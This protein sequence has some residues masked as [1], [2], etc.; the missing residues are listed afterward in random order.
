MTF[1]SNSVSWTDARVE[2]LTV[3]W[4][5]G[6]SASQIASRLGGVTRNA[7]IGKLH[8]LGVAGRGAPSTPRTMRPPRQA[9]HR[10]VVQ[11]PTRTPG[12]VGRP[13]LVSGGT[14]P[15]PVIEGPPLV[16][17]L[18]LLGAHACRWPIGDPRSSAFG[19]CGRT[20]QRDPYCVDHAC[21][22][23]RAAAPFD[24]KGFLR[25]VAGLR[26]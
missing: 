23:Y 4:R 17:D 6:L 18:A 2:I 5:D 15:S 26:P 14:M 7:V 13:L 25:L 10:C 12:T 19:F 8:R 16:A 3:L 11:R 20:C 22:A 1:P 24:Q 21:R 9:A